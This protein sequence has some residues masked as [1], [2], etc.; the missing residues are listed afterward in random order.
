MNSFSQHSGK[1]IPEILFSCKPKIKACYNYRKIP[2][3][4][5]LQLHRN[6]NLSNNLT[7]L[8]IMVKVP[9]MNNLTF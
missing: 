8:T 4:K 1:T 7:I 9:L 6:T 2:K 5:L 3:K